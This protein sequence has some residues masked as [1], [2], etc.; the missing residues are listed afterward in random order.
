[1][2]RAELRRLHCKR[3][4]MEPLTPK[5]GFTLGRTT[6]SK[7]RICLALCSSLWLAACGTLVEFADGVRV[8]CQD[9]DVSVISVPGR[10][11]VSPE[12]VEVCRGYSLTLN[13]RNLT[14]VGTARTRQTGGSGNP[15]I[16]V[17]NTS[18]D[19]IVLEVPADATPGER[20]Y[21]FEVDGVGL[22]DPRIV[23]Q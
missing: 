20:K 16:D 1:M 8:R 6:M 18:T 2:I 23:V 15:W 14:A 11:K 5:D 19:R 21:T 7:A 3:R 13:F 17:D 22:L 10:L 4:L 12:R 9:E